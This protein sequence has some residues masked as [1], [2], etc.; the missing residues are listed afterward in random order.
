MEGVRSLSHRMLWSRIAC[1]GT[2]LRSSPVRTSLRDTRWGVQRTRGA[3]TERGGGGVG[4]TVSN[5]PC[6][7]SSL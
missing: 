6:M 4:G 7:G 3:D 1:R 5:V 2:P